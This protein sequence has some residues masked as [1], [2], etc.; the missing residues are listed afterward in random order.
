MKNV[1]EEKILHWPREKVKSNSDSKNI[2]IK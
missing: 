1:K 2:E